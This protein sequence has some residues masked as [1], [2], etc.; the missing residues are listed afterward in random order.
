MENFKLSKAFLAKYADKK[1]P[2]G[3]NG[4]GELVYLRTYSRLKED[5]T[6]EK[7]FE[8]VARVVEGTYSMQKR[9]IEEHQLG[10]DNRRAQKSAQ[11]MYDRIFNMK[12]LPPG[13][14]LWAMG[15]PIVEERGINAC[16]SNCAFVSTKNLRED[17]SKPFTFLMDA[18]MLGVGVGF[19]TK[20]VGTITIKQ[21][22][23]NKGSWIF[24]I[25]DS[26]EGWVES[27][28]H[29]LESYFLGLSRVDFDYS[30]IREA[31]L[32]IKGFGGISSGPKPLKEMHEMVR[33]LLDANAGEPITIT[34]IVDIM[35]LIGKCVVAGNVR[36]CLPKGTLV[37]TKD[38]LV[39]IEDIQPGM[40]AKTSRGFS[41]I[42]ELV[43]QGEQEVISV[44]TQL[45]TFKCTAKHKFAK[46]S[47]PTTYEWVL[48]KD[49]KS[50]DRVVFIEGGIDG[51]ET[52]FPQFTYEYPK[53]ST[54]CKA[55]TIPTLDT[56][57][58]WFLGL[59]H[60]NGYVYAN[61]E[62]NGF[63]A[64]VSVACSPDY[65]EIVDNCKEQMLRFGINLYSPPTKEYDKCYKIVAQSKQLAYFLSEFKQPNESINV[66]DFILKGTFA[67]R[68][69]YLAGLFDADG[70][71]T[72][73]PL[74]A[75]TSVYPEYLRQIQA[76][77][78]SVG[79]PTRLKLVRDEQGSWQK[80][81]SLAVV[82]ERAKQQFLALLKQ[83]SK[84]YK[85][86][87]LS[88][89]NRSQNDYSF[90]SEWIA[91]FS[92]NDNVTV[93][94]YIDKGLPFDGLIP[95]TVLNVVETGE[96]VETYDISVPDAS[97]FVCQEGLLVHNTA[98]IVFGDY[99]S[100]EYINLKNYQQNPHREVYGWTSNNSI[101]ADIGMD[102][103]K[104]AER[105][106]DNGE[107]GLA[108]LEN[109]RGYS[110]M[111]NGMDNKDSRAEG[112]N[113][114]SEQT[115]ESWE[116]CCL[117]ENFPNKHDSLED[118]L[119]TL[120]FSY[121]YAKTV[122]LGKTHWPET[123]RVL[124]RNRRIGCSMS[125]IA[126][127]ISARGLDTLREWCLK[128]YDAI[129]E[130]DKA[131]SDWF[132][133]PRSIKTTSIKPSGS[134]SLLV[135][136][137]PGIHYPE[138][139]FYIRRVRLS[140]DSPLVKPLQ[141]AKY[142]IEPAFGSEDSTLVVEIPVD[143][144]EGVR[145]LSKVSMWEQL[146][147]AAFIQK[148]WADNQVSA[149]I[150]FDPDSEGDDIVNALNFF[151]Y[152]LKGISFLPRLKGG[153]YRQMPYEAISEETYHALK[154]KL[155]KVDFSNTVNTEIEIEKFCNNDVCEIRQK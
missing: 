29:L 100:D 96:K 68:C 14:G 93:A 73:R 128:G 83:Y 36:R 74:V 78:A 149:T 54:T 55:I 125:G 94:R 85:Y 52:S 90:P 132:A 32:P 67:V 153:A 43:Y 10:W 115:L 144:G 152:Q 137:T 133:I 59:F 84:A 113:P 82:G 142:T 50:S 148:Y 18:S 145:D 66:P 105:I 154:S 106:K 92:Q 107:P 117:V 23:P 17:L 33:N 62:N 47:S 21:P 135:G 70:G 2:F 16:L 8:T 41:R 122:T 24:E 45:G 35:N 116:T 110:R 99:D 37:H 44:E 141:K 112:S 95:V 71:K 147:L 103:N 151:Q 91:G 75:V 20:G 101:F 53:H 108:W 25:P 13:R 31:G 7:W 77:Y 98:E 48:A 58:A 138:S 124:L 79:I 129:Q 121:L 131:Y 30:K 114:C 11:E 63:N 60:G 69:A 6:N 39:K 120:K 155:K 1:P 139:R 4:L 51:S 150:T 64:S 89:T 80:L 42:S 15:S 5:G 143:C 28:Q 140:K 61:K 109:M 88:K 46:L 57:S 118:Y 111:N 87:K 97:E 22:H 19:D 130:Y 76:L 123:N 146:S 72:N 26:R 49:L 119:R 86:V 81:Y 136:A 38:G 65:P 12:F 102:Y 40:L 127:F 104:I 34:T 56:G 9:W 3:F 126:Q 27:L 134:V